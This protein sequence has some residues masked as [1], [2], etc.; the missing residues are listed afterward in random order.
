MAIL[1]IVSFILGI[2]PI[3]LSKIFGWK[4]EEENVG[5]VP[6]KSYSTKS[7]LFITAIACF[8]AG[9]ILTTAITHMLPGKSK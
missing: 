2:L 4:K 1:G 8:G 6:V 5:D 7:Q 3:K 9:V